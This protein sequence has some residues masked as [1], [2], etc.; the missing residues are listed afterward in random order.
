MS[1]TRL[2]I[3][4]NNMLPESHAATGGVYKEVV[5]KNSRNS[6]K[7]ICPTLVLSCEFCEIRKNTVFTEHLRATASAE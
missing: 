5:L 1:K 2:S 6:Q 7:N 4:K 3:T